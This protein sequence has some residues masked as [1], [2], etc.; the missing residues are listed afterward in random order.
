MVLRAYNESHPEG[1]SATVTVH[2]VAQPVHYVAAD[3]ANPV[4]PYTSWATAAT[5]IQ[6]AVDA[7]TVPGALVLVTNGVYATGG[8]AVYGT[9]TN[10]VAVDKPLTV[11]SVN[12]PEF[13]VI[14]GYQ[15]PGTTNG[16]GAIRCVYLTNGA[17]LSG[18]TL[19]NG[20]TRTDGDDYREQSGGGVW[21]E[22][23]NAVVSNCVLTGNSAGTY[24]GGAYGG[25]L[26]N[27]TLTGNSARYAA[28]GRMASTLNN[29]TL[30]G[31]S[32]ARRRRGVLTAR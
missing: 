9:M 6:D 12:G 10:R 16:D 30:T 29:C 22:S 23:A 14:Q 20:A 13:T 18:F 15:V 3:S 17:S 24:G 27:C 32:A 28:A 1:V 11:R 2:V 8:R 5:N 25:T 21:C 19:T 7:A 4:P 31:N 26:N